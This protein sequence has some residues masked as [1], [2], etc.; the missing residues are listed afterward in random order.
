MR[1]WV[2][3]GLAYVAIVVASYIGILI[4]L[5]L[6]PS[7]ASHDGLL[8]SAN[9][10]SPSRRWYETS[11]AR[12]FGAIILSPVIPVIFVLGLCVRLNE[13]FHGD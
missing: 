10:E 8:E 5:Q 12:F 13:K 3:V 9:L 6:E 4:L 2:T 1:F 11:L 7:E